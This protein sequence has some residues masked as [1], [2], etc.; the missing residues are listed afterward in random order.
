M[1]KGSSVSCQAKPVGTKDVSSNSKAFVCVLARPGVSESSFLW[2]AKWKWMGQQKVAV[3]HR[4]RFQSLLK[5][6]QRFCG[7][8]PKKMLV[9]LSI[10]ESRILTSGVALLA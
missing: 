8:L 6:D 5:F 2:I 7:E 4:C 9:N 3:S 1:S 10:R